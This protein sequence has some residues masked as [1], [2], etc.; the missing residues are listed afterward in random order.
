[1]VAF[2]K[3]NHILCYRIDS[4]FKVKHDALFSSSSHPTV[5]ISTTVFI[6]FCF[7]YLWGNKLFF[8][9]FR[10]DG[11]ISLWSVW[12]Q[13]RI[14]EDI[15]WFFHR[16][17]LVKCDWIH[18]WLSIISRHRASPRQ[19]R[20]RFTS[21]GNMRFQ[22]SPPLISCFIVCLQWMFVQNWLNNS[23]IQMQQ[24]D[25]SHLLFKFVTMKNIKNQ[26]FEDR[27]HA[28]HRLLLWYQGLTDKIQ[29]SCFF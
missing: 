10:W 6:P 14:L 19:P 18:I 2:E 12:G 26:Q 24:T 20:D 27:S 8:L 16:K 15:L 29:S 7:S 21:K 11:R 3:V 5:L 4:R 17:R 23:N 22:D 9:S 1:M 25:F 13:R 28:N